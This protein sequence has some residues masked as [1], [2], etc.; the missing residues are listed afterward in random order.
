MVIEKENMRERKSGKMSGLQD[1]G[2][3]RKQEHC[4]GTGADGTQHNSHVA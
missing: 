4:S 3:D 1:Y 2:R